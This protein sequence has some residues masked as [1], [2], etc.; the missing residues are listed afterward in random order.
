[1]I[2]SQ[3]KQ[4][5]RI[6]ADGVVINIDCKDDDHDN[7]NDDDDDDHDHD[8]N[9]DDDDDDDDLVFGLDPSPKHKS[10]HISN[11]TMSNVY[12]PRLRK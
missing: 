12:N 7:D 1:M 9:D 10:T 5:Y 4:T 3:T 6:H 2:H 8:D 11:Y